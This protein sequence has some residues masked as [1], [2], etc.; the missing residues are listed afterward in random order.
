MMAIRMVFTL[1]LLSGGAITTEAGNS[2]GNEG[3]KAGETGEAAFRHPGVLNTREELD[4]M[5]K[6]VQAGRQPWK[7]AFEQMN[8]S[9]YA[10]LSYSAHPVAV[11]GCGP[12]SNLK[13][14]A[15]GSLPLWNSM[16]ASSSA[17]RCHPGSAT[18][19]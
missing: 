14:R 3:G 17:S 11:V 10:S 19:P 15:S 4:F 8:S 13:N 12:Y 18:E 1:L 2:P 6:Q 16:P 9:S 5:K 7:L